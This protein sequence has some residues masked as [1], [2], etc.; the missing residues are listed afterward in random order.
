[1]NKKELVSML[2]KSTGMQQGD[3]AAVVE[4]CFKTMADVLCRGERVTIRNF[5]SFSIRKRA[6][7]RARNLANQQMMEVPEHCVV[8]FEPSENFA[9]VIRESEKLN[10]MLKSGHSFKLR[11]PPAPD[12]PK[13]PK[14]RRKKTGDE[15]GAAPTSVPLS[16]SE[17]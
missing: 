5:G 6:A 1:M 4:G 14:H 13:N 7:R 15:T 17:E 8:D 10:Q 11:S 2:A 16:K 12:T 9:K 3:V